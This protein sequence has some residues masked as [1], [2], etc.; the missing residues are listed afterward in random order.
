[1]TAHNPPIDPGVR[2]GHVHLKVADLPRSL[3][4]YCDV[5]G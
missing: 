3:E 1:M 4:F 2:I 5:L